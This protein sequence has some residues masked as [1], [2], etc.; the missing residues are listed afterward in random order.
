[1]VR[2]HC[3]TSKTAT[4]GKPYISQIMVLPIPYRVHGVRVSDG[5][6]EIFTENRGLTFSLQHLRTQR[7]SYQCSRVN[8]QISAVAVTK[9]ASLSESR[10]GEQS[11]ESYVLV[12]SN[13][14]RLLI[15]VPNSSII[16]IRKGRLPEGAWSEDLGNL[17]RTTQHNSNNV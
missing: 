3:N 13:F 17:T 16:C 2:V 10:T 4:C 15:N 6:V 9:L 1:M 11:S 5:D 12:Y 7:R 8:S 14:L